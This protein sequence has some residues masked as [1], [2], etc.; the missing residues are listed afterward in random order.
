MLLK[1][2]A[3]PRRGV[4]S[5]EEFMR[6]PNPRFIFRLLLF[7][8]AL[9]S[10]PGMA[11]EYTRST[12]PK[13]TCSAIEVSGPIEIGE[14]D[15]FALFMRETNAI[16]PL[17][18]IYLNSQ[19]GSIFTTVAIAELVRASVPKVETIVQSGQSCNSACV[20]LLTVGSR[21]YIGSGATLLIH[22]AFDPRTGKRDADQ[23]KEL[24]KYLASHGMPTENLQTFSNLTPEE[25]LAITPSN[26]RQLGFG[27]LTYYGS[28]DPPATPQ[29]S[30]EGFIADDP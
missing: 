19:G 4:A 25:Q 17:R 14:Y 24:G 18:R 29:C 15:R 9:Q 8:I 21:R 30:W 3:H 12:D 11:A 10:T 16:A 1:R 23:T 7:G 28:T 26:A 27:T 20:I 5:V 13:G 2:S 6:K 22:Q